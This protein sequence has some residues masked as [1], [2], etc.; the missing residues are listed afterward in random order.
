MKDDRE[1]DFDDLIKYLKE[2]RNDKNLLSLNVYTELNETVVFEGNV[3]ETRT[4]TIELK[5]KINRKKRKF[6]DLQ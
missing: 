2:H 6:E 5:Y 1:K 4:I 3:T